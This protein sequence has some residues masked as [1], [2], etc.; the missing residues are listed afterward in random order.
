LGDKRTS[1]PPNPI[2]PIYESTASPSGSGFAAN[3]N[4]AAP[5]SKTADPRPAHNP[6]RQIFAVEFECRAM[7]AQ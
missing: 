7:I 2:A 6:S 3:L 4:H 1:D 5:W